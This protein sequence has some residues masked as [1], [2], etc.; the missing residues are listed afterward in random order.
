MAES[1]SNAPT[2]LL[3]MIL[4]AEFMNSVDEHTQ[5][6]RIDIGRDAVPEIEHMS[7]TATVLGQHVGDPRADFVIGQRE[8]GGLEIA[9]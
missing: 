3:R 1:T 6:V 5:I 9:L 8:R 7:G 4:R 2:G